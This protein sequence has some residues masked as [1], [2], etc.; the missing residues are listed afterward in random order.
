M[1][2]VEG[3]SALFNLLYVLGLIRHKR[4]AWPAGLLGCLLASFLFFAQNLYLESTLNLAYSAMAVYGWMQWGRPGVT[5][6]MRSLKRKEAW[7]G[8]FLGIACSAS[9]ALV[10]ALYSPNPNPLLDSSIF[11]FSLIATYLQ[12]KRVIE[13]WHTWIITNLAMVFLCFVRDLP[14]YAAYSAIMMA[15]AWRGLQIWKRELKA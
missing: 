13:N 4:W 15:M 8:L 6:L 3:F 7:L 11:T 1:R 9:L 5:G 12:A 2:W 10:F 14:I